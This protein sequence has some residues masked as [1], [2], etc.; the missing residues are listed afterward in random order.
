MEY[1]FRNLVFITALVFSFLVLLFSWVAFDE[2]YTVQVIADPA[3]IASYG[4]G[5]ENVMAQRG[6]HFESAS[7]Y[8]QW[9]FIQ[10]L[11]L[12]LVLAIGIFSAIKRNV[13]LLLL[14]GVIFSGLFFFWRWFFAGAS[15]PF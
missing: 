8:S 15:P 14:S 2:W 3:V 1:S 10:G 11:S 13:W 6:W 5:N 9:N 7:T 12:L 4:F